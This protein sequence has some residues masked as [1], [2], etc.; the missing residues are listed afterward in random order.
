[1]IFASFAVLTPLP[2]TDL[3]EEV[4]DQMILHDYDYFD[5]IHTLLPTR[6]PLKKFYQEYHSLYSKGIPFMKQLEFL[7]KFP[8]R[9]IPD[10]LLNGRRFYAQLK[11]AYKDYQ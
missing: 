3:F 2:A 1:M 4:K 10:L 7:S 9:E 5:F 6:L 8:G 11:S